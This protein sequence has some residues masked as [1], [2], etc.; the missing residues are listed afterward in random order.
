MNA[1]SEMIG[2]WREFGTSIRSR[3]G[4]WRGYA[5]YEDGSAAGSR[6]G[7][8]R[9]DQRTR[10]PRR[11]RGLLS[12]AS[13]TRAAARRTATSAHPSSEHGPILRR[14]MAGAGGW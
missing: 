4:Q 5:S 3:R 9:F 14:A 11:V 13:G 12:S 1:T 2:D 10:D 7:Y 8:A 6:Y